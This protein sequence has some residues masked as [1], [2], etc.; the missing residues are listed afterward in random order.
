MLLLWHTPPTGLPEFVTAWLIQAS[1]D[2][3]ETDPAGEI[4]PRRA[5]LSADAT[6][7]VSVQDAA[8]QAD[9]YGAGSAETRKTVSAEDA[10][11]QANRSGSSSTDAAEA[12]SARRATI[13]T[14]RY[15]GTN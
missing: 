11:I 14:D 13:P 7:N 2:Q 9:G 10:E 8:I 4:D 3:I 6:E 15:R 12:L 5:S 1:R